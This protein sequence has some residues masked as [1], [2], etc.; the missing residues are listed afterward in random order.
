[1]ENRGFNF[2][3]HKAAGIRHEDFGQEFMKA[4]LLNNSNNRWVAYTGI[5]DYGY[6]LKL[7][8]GKLLPGKCDEF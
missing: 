8:D 3:Y 7:Y 1:M 5:Y 2:E 6:L 4:G